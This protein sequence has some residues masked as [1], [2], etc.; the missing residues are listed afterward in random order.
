VVG[1]ATRDD[2]LAGERFDRVICSETL[3][4]TDRPAD[5]VRSM[6]RLLADDGVAVITVPIERYKNGIKRALARLGLMTFLLRGIEHGMSE[7]HVQDFRPE[8]ILKLV[9]GRFEVRRRSTVLLL[10]DVYAMDKL[11]AR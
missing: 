11:R 2:F 3:E 7:W 10:H 8:D 5:I 6:Y 9:Q 1:D 4:H